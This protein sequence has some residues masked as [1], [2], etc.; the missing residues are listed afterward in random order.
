MRKSHNIICSDK[1]EKEKLTGFFSIQKD[2]SVFEMDVENLIENEIIVKLKD[3]SCHSITLKNKDNAN[4]LFILIKE[5]KNGK[6]R[7]VSLENLNYNTE[8]QIITET[9]LF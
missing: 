5:I 2:D 9:I 6:R 3:K 4:T 8:I 1:Y 7:F